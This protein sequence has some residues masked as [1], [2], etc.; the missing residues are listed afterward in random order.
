MQRHR[1][2]EFVVVLV[3]ILEAFF[4]HVFDRAR[5]DPAVLFSSAVALGTPFQA[6]Y[7]NSTYRV[8]DILQILHWN[9]AFHVPP[10]RNLDNVTFVLAVH[11][12]LYPFLGRLVV[13]FFRPLVSID[14][15]VRQAIVRRQ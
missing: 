2:D 4:P 13:L 12:W 8:V 5:V 1:E 3:E 11:K 9:H 15:P 6:P 7:M 10:A 14:K